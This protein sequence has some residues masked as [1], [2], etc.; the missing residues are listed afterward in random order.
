[1]ASVMNLLNP[2][3]LSYNVLNC[4]TVLELTI[5][6]GKAFHLFINLTENEFILKVLKALGFNN[7]FEF[8]VCVSENSN[9]P[10]MEMLSIFCTILK[11]RI[12]SIQFLRYN[13]VVTWPIIL[14]LMA[15][16]YV[17]K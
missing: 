7:F 13:K 17:K 10:S 1:M 12:I 15:N 8:Q 9:K 11:T 2:M 3:C 4:R 16:C 5:S 6:S 14:S